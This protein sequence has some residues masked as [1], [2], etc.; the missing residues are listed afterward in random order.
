VGWGCV[1][2][3]R[4]EVSCLSVIWGHSIKERNVARKSD[5][6]GKEVSEVARSERGDSSFRGR[7][8][9]VSAVAREIDANRAVDEDN[10]QADLAGDSG[11]EGL[12]YPDHSDGPTNDEV[13][14]ANKARLAKGEE[15]VAEASADVLPEEPEEGS[16]MEIRNTVGEDTMAVRQSAVDRVVDGEIVRATENPST[17]GTTRDQ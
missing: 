10:P 1:N 12:L 16:E 9:A 4:N 17:M 15:P 7:G 5:N 14:A 3:I 13:E 11:A 8:P 2:W 6:H